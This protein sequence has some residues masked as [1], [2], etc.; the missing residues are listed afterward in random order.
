M[1]QSIHMN[2]Y[3][4]IFASMVTKGCVE[5][6]KSVQHGGAN[7]STAGMY[8]TGAANLADSI[9]AIE[10][11]VFEDKDITMDQLIKACDANFEGYE[12]IR[13]LLLNKPEKYGNNQEHVDSIYKEMMHFI[14]E[15]VQSWKDAR[16]GHYSFGIDS[17]TMNIPH[18]AVTG[19]LPDGR[20]AGEPL[21][22]AAS[23]MMGRDLNGPTATVKSV[24]SIEPEKLEE[25][26]LFNLRFDPRGV[27]GE[28]GLKIIEGVIKTFFESG[29]QHIQ[30]NVVDN[31]TLKDAQ[32]NP[33]NYK[34]LMVRVAGY[35]AYFTQLDKSAQDAIIYRT[36]HLS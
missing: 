13:Q 16:G 6:G 34:G 12:R 15:N 24:A 28:K 5:R 20:L 33:E 30:I 10:K 11:C 17:Q 35:M 22:D 36:A 23:P 9:A 26:A 32:K 27:Q 4:V 25:G 14:A 1:M 18:G 2:R 19:A 8:V 21:C 7:Y 29:G 3:P 31:E